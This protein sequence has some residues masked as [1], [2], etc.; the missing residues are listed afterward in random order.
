MPEDCHISLAWGR[1]EKIISYLA[2]SDIS[3]KT[4]LRFSATQLPFLII[5]LLSHFVFGM[6]L[7]GYVLAENPKEMRMLDF[8]KKKL[9]KIASFP[10]R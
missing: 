3:K 1:G 4:F 6:S 9:E 5:Y 10:R 8:H 7:A 2:I